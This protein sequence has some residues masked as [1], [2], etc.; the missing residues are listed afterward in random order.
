[1]TTET[2]RISITGFGCC[3]GAGN[4][5][6]SVWKSIES[7]RV[8]CAPATPAFFAPHK[9]SPL[10][11]VNSKDLI[12]GLSGSFFHNRKLLSLNT[13]NRTTALALTA[14]DEAL[15]QAQIDPDY[16]SSLR[17][18]VILGT[19][20]GCTFYDE[21]YYLN[22]QEG[23][24]QDIS[25]VSNY[26]SNNLGERVQQLLQVNG[27]R[28]VVTNAC[29]SGTDAIGLAKQWLNNDMC[30][31]AI[32]GGADEV[33]R[34]AC[35]GFSSLMLFSQNPCRPFD[36]DRQ[37]LN[38]G[39]GAGV[40]I[41][42]KNKLVQKRKAKV[43]GYIRGYGSACDAY[44]PTAPHP[45][46]HGLQRAIKIAMQDADITLEQLCY[47]NGHGTGTQANDQAE[48]TALAQLSDP[49]QNSLP[50]VSTKG[51]TGH[52]LGAAGGIEAVVTLMALRQ[53]K[54]PGTIGCHT[55]DPRL[56]LGVLRENE[57]F[58]FKGNLG[59]SQS[60]AFG[61]GNSALIVEANR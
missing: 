4:N 44:H 23:K 10:F 53:G 51:A 20:V 1:M 37:G 48:L 19:T 6:A 59:M 21:S 58:T 50:I 18:G 41:L 24:L 54:T 22:W 57:S 45:E 9:P 61:G 13:I 35:H 2:K 42:E 43:L 14:I 8:N 5:G 39:E 34:I 15:Q 30:D 40:V 33:S 36:K 27:P 29:A 52:T 7:N 31:L 11:L 25:P 12:T 55:Q 28:A 60:L 49:S 17:V 32:A 16:L 56:P 38:L 26:L 3:C 47:I 46:G